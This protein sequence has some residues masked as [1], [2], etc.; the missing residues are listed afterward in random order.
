MSDFHCSPPP[1][2]RRPPVQPLLHARHR[3]PAGRPAAKPVLARPRRACSTNWPSATASPPQI[4]AANWTL[5]PGYLSRILQRFER[6]GL[7]A[8]EPS[9]ADRRQGLLSLT[10]A[11]RDAFAP[12]DA[13]SR[14]EVAALLRRCRTRRRRHWSPRWAASRPCSAA[15]QSG[16]LAA[17]PASARRHRLGRG[18]AR[19]AV[20]RGVRLRCPLRGVGGASCRRV[21]RASTIR[22]ASAAG[23]PSATA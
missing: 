17:A 14:E 18:A 20:R 5:D 9:P 6:D 16:A 12:L 8:R 11:G 2:R 23:S 4:S 19:R 15:P 22:R 7:L 1:R 13:R 21:P 3:R 10:A